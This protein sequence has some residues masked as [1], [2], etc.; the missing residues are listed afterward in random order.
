M[1]PLGIALRKKYLS[2]KEALIALGLDENLIG[3]AGPD[4]V[5]SDENPFTKE[6]TMTRKEKKLEARAAALK[7][8]Q[9]AGIDKTELARILLA[10]DA[11][12]AKEDDKDDKA[13]PAVDADDQREDESDE[14]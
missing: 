13:N 2:P 3:R 1:T 6:K 11:D 5:V 4:V 8:A 14:D 10:S 9:D 7:V 12:V